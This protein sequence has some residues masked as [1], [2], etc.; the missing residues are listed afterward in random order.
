MLHAVDGAAKIEA[1]QG[2]TV[3][4][5]RVQGARRHLGGIVHFLLCSVELSQQLVMKCTVI[6]HGATSCRCTPSLLKPGGEGC[7]PSL[8]PSWGE[9]LRMVSFRHGLDASAPVTRALCDCRITTAHFQEDCQ[10]GVSWAAVLYTQ[11]TSNVRRIV[12]EWGVSLPT[13]GGVLVQWGV[14][15][16]A[17]GQCRFY[18]PS[19]GRVLGYVVPIQPDVTCVRQSTNSS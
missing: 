2:N 4:T 11:L 8:P 16:R 9:H 5:G 1:Q 18:W 17:Y 10:Y 7:K 15:P 19:A 14:L 3:N 12:P 6:A 13:F